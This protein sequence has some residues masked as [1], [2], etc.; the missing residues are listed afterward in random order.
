MRRLGGAAV[1]L[2]K[3]DRTFHDELIPQL[4]WIGDTSYVRQVNLYKV[5]S[6]QEERA[7]FT[8]KFITP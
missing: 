8:G 7:N 4:F 1:D 2:V 3:G 6:V 5:D